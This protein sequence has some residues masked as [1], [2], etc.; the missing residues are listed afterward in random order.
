LPTASEYDEGTIARSAPVRK[1]LPEADL[2]AA[3]D[4]V[5]A[6]DDLFTSFA[7]EM[8]TCGKPGA[9]VENAP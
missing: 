7:R 2:F 4:H 9:R 3:P 5:P 6:D 1:N 8:G